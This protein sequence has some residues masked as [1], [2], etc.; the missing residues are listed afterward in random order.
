MYEGLW[1]QGVYHG[2]GNVYDSTKNQNIEGTFINGTPHGQVVITNKKYIFV[3][4]LDHGVKNGEGYL[5]YPNNTIRHGIW[6][7]RGHNV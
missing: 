5:I 3:G 6:Y 4:N 2:L 7:N 1:K